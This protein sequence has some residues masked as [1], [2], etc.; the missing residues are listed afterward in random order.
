VS[1]CKTGGCVTAIWDVLGGLNLVGQKY[2]SYSHLLPIPSGTF[3]DKTTTQ[4]S[5]VSYWLDCCKVPMYDSNAM[6]GLGRQPSC[7]DE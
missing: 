3:T 1:I 7:W 5:E 2:R 4:V 6:S